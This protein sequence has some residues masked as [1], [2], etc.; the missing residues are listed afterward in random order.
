MTRA[1]TTAALLA[2]VAFAA[3]RRG[4]VSTLVFLALLAVG[5]LGNAERLVA[6]ARARVLARQ[7]AEHLDSAG[8]EETGSDRAGRPSAGQAFWVT[9]DGSGLTVSGYR[10][11]A[12]PAREARQ[13]GFTTAPGG[14]LF[15]AGAS[16]SGKTT[17]LH[18]IAAALSEVALD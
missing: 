1:M 16:G 17:L 10:L 3:Q 9:H 7:A 13:I 15:V 2:T 4:S 11:P 6:A 8:N 12:T 5:V 14:T 18:A